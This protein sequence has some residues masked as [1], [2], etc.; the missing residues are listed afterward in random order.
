MPSFSVNTHRKPVRLLTTAEADKAYPR[1][2]LID[3]DTNT[4][5]YKDTDGKIRSFSS[6]L[7]SSIGII[8]SGNVITDVQINQSTHVIEFIKGTINDSNSG[9][10]GNSGSSGGNN[11]Q[12][13]S[14]Q[15][16]PPVSIT[17]D[18]YDNIAL[19]FGS[20]F[21]VI[22]RI[23]RDSYG[24]IQS[25]RIRTITL[26]DILSLQNQINSLQDKISQ[27]ESQY[28]NN[29]SSST[30]NATITDN[31]LVINDTNATTED[32]YIV[33]ND[34]SYMITED[35]YLSFTSRTTSSDIGNII[36]N[37]GCR[38]CCCHCNN[39][40]NGDKKDISITDDSYLSFNDSNLA[41]IT[42]S[43]YLSIN[44]SANANITEDECISFASQNS[45]YSSCRC[46]CRNNVNV[47]PS[48]SPQGCAVTG[49]IWGRE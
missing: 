38:C 27:L 5:K 46:C 9:N 14:S 48:P 1:E 29:G 31:M 23:N 7:D 17:N 22:D 25:I 28:K 41:D 13:S 2:P 10:N 37:S 39:S 45:S 49:C 47:S 35:E 19:P 12:G 40:N 32:E 21:D 4:I 8:G 30:N 20:S 18:I 16:H 33:L 15:Q 3:I 44:D 43:Q 11:D 34:S 42:E 6:D 26:P 24:H 36:I